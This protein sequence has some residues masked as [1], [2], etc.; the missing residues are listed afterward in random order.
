[1]LRSSLRTHRVSGFERVS[2]SGRGAEGGHCGASD[3]RCTP[4]TRQSRLPGSV[5]ASEGV[6]RLVK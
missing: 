5:R 4:G 6:E 2:S 3:L 1:M